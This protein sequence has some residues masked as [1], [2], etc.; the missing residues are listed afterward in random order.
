ME[1]VICKKR[2]E[3]QCICDAVWTFSIEQMFVVHAKK[4]E[5]DENVPELKAVQWC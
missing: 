5:C 1:S 4:L 2:F 3:T